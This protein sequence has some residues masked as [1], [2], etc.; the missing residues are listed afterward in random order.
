MSD[1][2]VRVFAL[3]DYLKNS[4]GTGVWTTSKSWVL[5]FCPLCVLTPSLQL[6][7]SFSL[8]DLFL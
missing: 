1:L 3:L 6:L 4:V 7:K 2:M 5:S 8:I